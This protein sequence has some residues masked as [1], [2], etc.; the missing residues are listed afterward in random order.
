MAGIAIKRNQ[1]NNA[2]V[3]YNHTMKQYY[4]PA[5]YMMGPS[6]LLHSIFPDVVYG[7]GYFLSFCEI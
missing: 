2:M 3:F 5:E 1:T 7:G 6:R 4:T